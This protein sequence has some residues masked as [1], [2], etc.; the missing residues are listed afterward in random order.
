M[1]WCMTAQ[2]ANLVSGTVCKDCA[3]NAFWNTL[4]FALERRGVLYLQRTIYYRV[5]TYT[6]CTLFG[7]VLSLQS[8][9]WH[10]LLWG[11]VLLSMKHDWKSRQE[12]STG[13]AQ[14]TFQRWIESNRPGLRDVMAG[15]FVVHIGTVIVCIT[16]SKRSRKELFLFQDAW[17]CLWRPASRVK[18]AQ[19]C[20]MIKTSRSRNPILLVS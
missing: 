18:F 20:P 6:G 9:F 5:R 2:E 1:F 17:K 19:G 16:W 12:E 4:G 11:S 13:E 7:R 8:K 3:F 15:L 14:N 10:S